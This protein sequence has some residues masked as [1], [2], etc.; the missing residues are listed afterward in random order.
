MLDLD[1]RKGVWRRSDGLPDIAWCEVPAGSFFM[2][3]DLEVE[4]TRWDGA[5]VDIAYPF[6]VG[7]YP[8]T[9]AQYA[10]FIEA[11]G[12][13]DRRWWTKGGWESKGARSLPHYWDD[14]RWHMSN[15]PV[16]GVSWYEAHAFTRWLDEKARSIP[17][18]LPEA[19][20]GLA[21]QTSSHP[22][23][24]L[25]L[26]AEREKAVRYPDGRK[27]AWGDSDDDP[28]ANIQ[29]MNPFR[30][31]RTSPVGIYQ[32]GAAPCGAFDLCGNVFDWCLSVY[33]EK[34]AWP[35]NVDSEGTERRVARGGSWLRSLNAARAAYR[36]AVSPET[37][38]D[39]QGFRLVVSAPLGD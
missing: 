9:Y 8:V 22:L 12:Y 6:W 30:L 28:P 15:H 27:F 38:Y 19:L 3:G 7:K 39:D 4:G 29:E 33:R 10:A 34:Y 16:V 11:D 36:E 35:E 26:E 20:R 13:G 37:V 5:H 1:D 21:G 24:R 17:D 25:P 31:G 2:G 32:K 23:I 14:A 18:L